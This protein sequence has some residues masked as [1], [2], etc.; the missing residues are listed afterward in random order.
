MVRRNVTLAV[1]LL[2]ACSGAASARENLSLDRGWRF[3]LGD[4]EPFSLLPAGTPITA[5]EFLPVPGLVAGADSLTV[6][7]PAESSTGWRAVAV[8]EDAF[9]GQ[10]TFGWFRTTLSGAAL[11]SPA[12]W[13]T[14]V[15][16]NGTIYLNGIRIGRHDG[17]NEPFE[18]KLS[19]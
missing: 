11:K 4:P 3:H 9:N 19:P 10:K 18:L 12:I 8:D 17:W 16:D 2:I 7:L 15:D 13:F 14:M 5:W 6:P 1:V